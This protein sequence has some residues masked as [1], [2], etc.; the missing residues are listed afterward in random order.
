[1]K[2]LLLA[3]FCF[4]FSATISAQKVDT[5]LQEQ[6]NNNSWQNVS[7]I[8]TDYNA[9]CQPGTVLI[10]NWD[11]GS[12]TWENFALTTNTYTHV[13]YVKQALL[14]TWDKNSSSWKNV[15]RT[16]NTY[17][18]SDQVTV[19]LSELYTGG[20][21]QNASRTTNTY[22]AN[23]YLITALSEFWFINQWQN[24]SRINYTNNSDG[25]P[26]EIVY[27][28]WNLITQ[29]WDNNSRDTYTYNA[30]KTVDQIVHQVWVSGA[31]ENDTRTRYTYDASKRVL[32]VLS[33]DWDVSQWVNNSL[34]TT[35][36]NGNNITK[37][38]YQ[39]WNGSGWDNDNQVTFTYNGDGTVHQ[40]LFE[41]WNG[42]KWENELRYTFSYTSDCA[43]PLTLLNFSATKTNNTV[44]LTWQTANEVNTSH[45]TVQRSLDATSFSSVGNVTAKGNSS[46]TNSYGFTDDVTS[47]KSGKIY[48]RLQMVDNDGKFTYSKIATVNILSDGKFFVVYPNPVKDQLILVTSTTVN[49]AEIRITD[50]TGKLVYNQQLENVQA[51]VQNK[52]NVTSLGKGIYNLQLITNSDKQTTRFFKD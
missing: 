31:W 36:Y 44:S 25:T 38:L 27:Q 22:D 50:Q 33:E 35:T 3:I 24:V 26:Q 15:S 14:Q 42:S 7:R 41:T 21:W 6:W 34:T 4:S 40:E 5:V 23:G 20:A 45:F 48:Y 13:I 43:L 47:I 1:M 16:T 32:T 9:D 8:I 52:I 17:N 29:K 37:I 28:T 30:D 12:Q 11:D 39:T 18:A 2:H 49:K 46:A 51:G 10:Q 19:A